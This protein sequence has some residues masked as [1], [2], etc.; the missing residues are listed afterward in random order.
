MSAVFHLNNKE[1]KH[2]LKVNLKTLPCCSEPKYLGVTFYRSL[3]YRWHLESFRKKFTSR[4]GLLRR[5]A[6]CGW[7][8]GA[9]TL[10]EA[11]L[12]L[13]RSTA[14][15]CAP[16]WCRSV[17][18]HLIDPAINDTLRIMTWCL[19]PTP[20]DSLPRHS[21]RHP[22]CWASLQWS[23]TFSSTPCYGAWTPA[24]LSTHLSTE[25]KCT[26]PQ[27]ETAICTSRT[28]TYQFIWQQQHT[29]GAL[30]RL[31]TEGGVDGQPHKT[32]HFHPWH[33]RSPPG[34]T[35][36]SR[37]WVQLNRLRTGVWRF[38]FCLYK[39]GMASSAACECD[40]EQQTVDHVVLQYRIHRPRHGLHSL[41]V[42]DNET[43]E[44]LVN[45]CSEIWCGQAV[46]RTTSGSIEEV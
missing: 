11:T 29:C 35:L 4:L 38:H 40:A 7:G 17:H 23:H 26:A 32:P 28:T 12:A 8:A 2:E 1:T 46:V 34:V 33:R 16:V 31:P 22:I 27:I 39:G 5:F 13:V 45:I 42:L 41:T 9:T 21:W 19:R 20:A 15:Y 36:P 10:R 43:I 3:A 6:G 14:V 44:W 37:A 30:G 24:P 18:T 25:C